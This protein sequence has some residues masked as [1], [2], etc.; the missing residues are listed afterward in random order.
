MPAE[1][2]EQ[3][4]RKKKQ[5]RAI[6]DVKRLRADVVDLI[7]NAKTIELDSPELTL[8]KSQ[9]AETEKILDGILSRA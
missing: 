9:L 4:E 6:K 1:L 8:A 2:D 3:D 7:A 5:E